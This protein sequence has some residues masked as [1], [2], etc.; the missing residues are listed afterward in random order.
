VP[1]LEAGRE[2]QQYNSL[3]CPA[4]NGGDHRE[5]NTSLSIQKRPPEEGGG[6][7]AMYHCWRKKNC[8]VA[9]RVPGQRVR[10]PAA[11]DS[12]IAC[13]CSDEGTLG[14]LIG[15]SRAVCCCDVHAAASQRLT[16][17]VRRARAAVRRDV[18]RSLAPEQSRGFKGAKGLHRGAHMLA[19]AYCAGLKARAHACAPRSCIN[20]R[21]SHTP[22]GMQMGGEAVVQSLRAPRKDAPVMLRTPDF[23]G[24]T[25]PLTAAGYAYLKKRGIAREVIDHNEVR[26]AWKSFKVEGDYKTLECLAFPFKRDSEVVNVKYRSLEGVRPRM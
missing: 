26:S 20:I 13:T 15:C 3:V 14:H 4:C 23:D 11:L 10:R 1:S 17:A 25:Q 5:S 16:A 8:G 2:Q 19:S 22:C 7:F 6:W 18:D 24:T 21:C 12:S 9:G